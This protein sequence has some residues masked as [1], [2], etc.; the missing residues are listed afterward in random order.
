MDLPKIFHR[1]LNRFWIVQR[2]RNLKWTPKEIFLI[3]CAQF[4]AMRGDCSRRQCYESA[5]ETLGKLR[6]RFLFPLMSLLFE[7]FFSLTSLSNSPRLCTISTL[8]SELLRFFACDCIQ[9]FHY[10]TAQ[11]IFFDSFFKLFSRFWL[12]STPNSPFSV[13]LSHFNTILHS[14]LGKSICWQHISTGI[15]MFFSRI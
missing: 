9:V 1:I 6:P 13:T 11:I 12:F 3:S 10:F 7:K 4:K 2:R 8:N 14:K 5:A 15:S